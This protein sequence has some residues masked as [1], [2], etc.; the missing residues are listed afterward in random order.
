MLLTVGVCSLLAAGC[1]RCSKSQSDA[2]DAAA[3]EAPK[4]VPIKLKLDEAG[5]KAAA[6]LAAKL[7]NERFPN[8]A[9]RDKNHAKLFLYLAATSEKPEVII[10]SLDALKMSYTSSESYKQKQIAD[11]DYGTVVAAHLDSSN[12]KIQGYA[13]EAASH[14][15][16]GKA[17]SAAVVQALVKIAS[18]HPNLAARS[19]AIDRLRLVR[20]FQQDPKIA[21]A[22]LKALDSDQPHLV[23]RA[24]FGLRLRATGLVM[25]NQ[26]LAKGRHLLKAADPGVR[27]RAAELV[28][29]LGAG[30]ED[31]VR[32]IEA[33]LADP[34]PFT[35]S[36][37]CAALAHLGDL[38][39]IHKLMKL[40]DDT[41]KNTYD[42]R[43][44]KL[45][46]DREGWVHFDGSAWSEVRDAALRSLERMSMKTKV[47]FVAD[48]VESA[49]VAGSLAKN[50]KAARAWYAK[51]KTQLP[52][53]RKGDAA[54]AQPK[55]Q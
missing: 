5:Q 21:E 53:E 8:E 50:A 49:D 3:T 15:V 2:A 51:V 29:R 45:P 48:K 54:A 34:H 52:P 20:D 37:A 24:L 6:D 12:L 30:N 16:G 1:S 40:M 11:D 38:G 32:E 26:F 23:A 17:P 4:G 13:L 43:G 25:R 10:A 7:K 47:R 44:F 35:R 42:I 55:A 9:V 36:A 19:E 39:S 33:L 31:V 28:G 46:T 18:S 27:G 14:A 41:E 22:F